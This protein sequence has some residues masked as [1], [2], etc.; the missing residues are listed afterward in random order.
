MAF[1]QQRILPWLIDKG[2]RN[3]AMT[4]YRPRLP[5]LAA[6]RVLEVGMGSGLNFPYY[7]GRVE[8]LYGLEPAE[9]LRNA[10]AAVVGLAPCPVTFLA[11]GAEAIPL[12]SASIDTVVSTWTLCSIPDV[13]DALKEMRRV[14]KPGGRLLFLE[15][16]RAPD[17][18]VV[19]LQNRL[20]PVFRLLA[21]CNLNRP[22]DSLLEN[23]G[24]AFNDLERGYLDGP[25]FI[26]YHY[27]GD[28]RI[29]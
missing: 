16:G 13:E 27:I 17:A 2:M 19:R 15:H 26:A 6:G 1:Y 23:A 8:H 5:P 20:A 4:K 25:R 12:E 3:K 7:T 18:K 28:A 24:F 10:A 14:L 9:Y 21:G 22:I 11:A 29:A